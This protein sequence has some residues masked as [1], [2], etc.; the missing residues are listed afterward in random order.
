[1]CAWT[2]S[3]PWVRVLPTAPASTSAPMRTCSTGPDRLVCSLLRRRRI[4]PGRQRL[5][6]R[7]AGDTLAGACLTRSDTPGYLQAIAVNPRTRDMSA[8]NRELSIALSHLRVM[9]ADGAYGWGWDRS[10]DD[11]GARLDSPLWPVAQ[12]AAELL[13]S[14]N[15]GRVKLCAGRAAAGSSWT[16]AATTAAGAT[17]ET[18]ATGRGYAATSLASGPPIVT[19]LARTPA[20]QSMRRASSP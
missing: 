19:P 15:L 18:A 10:G 13:T 7:N 2:S 8:L 3:I 14:P 5:T 6:R 12:S 16:K 9:P 20:S 17:R 4:S 11:G 1:M